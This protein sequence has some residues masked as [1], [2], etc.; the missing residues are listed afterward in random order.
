MSNTNV[1]TVTSIADRIKL[2]LAVL[3]IIAGIV[4]FSVLSDQPAVVRVALFIASLIV[5]AGI[6]WMS[7]PGRRT[8][9]FG[10]DSYG[11]LK[12]VVWPT[13]KE[14]MQMTGIVFVFVTIIGIFLWL[15]DKALGWV[16]YGLLL[17]WR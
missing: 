8:I 12:R 4:A 17:G 5:A 2:T 6:A 13:R 1:E 15:A 9:S 10:R 7:E 14:A 16:I 3:V 11:E